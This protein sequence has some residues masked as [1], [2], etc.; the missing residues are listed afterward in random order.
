MTHKRTCFPITITVWFKKD[1]EIKPAR[2]PFS[3]KRNT[4]F[5]TLTCNTFFK[6]EFYQ[7]FIGCTKNIWHILKCY[8]KSS[9]CR[10]GV[11]FGLKYFSRYSSSEKNKIPN[12]GHRWHHLSVC[13]LSNL[14]F[15]LIFILVSIW[16]QKISIYTMSLFNGS[17]HFCV[18]ESKLINSFLKANIRTNGSLSYRSFELII[19]H[20]FG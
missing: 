11:W 2:F 1:L 17:H 10:T 16:F 12:L 7:K 6:W 18:T 5:I 20:L 19:F 3:S 14:H 8:V 13:L 15:F 4:N 9:S